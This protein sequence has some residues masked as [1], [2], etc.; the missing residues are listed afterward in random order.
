MTLYLE[1][2]NNRCGKG[3]NF[4]LR[5]LAARK[6]PPDAVFL[7]NPDARLVDPGSTDGSISA[8]RATGQCSS[9]T[10]I[11]RLRLR[12][13]GWERAVFLTLGKV[14]EA[15]GAIGYHLAQLRGRKVRLIEY[16]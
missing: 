8:A 11:A 9:S 13:E 2:L 1:T 10:E 5:S 12:G 15:Q 6:G 7:R 3:N 14:A 16:K 4:V